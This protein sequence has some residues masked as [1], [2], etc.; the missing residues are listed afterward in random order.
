MHLV[1]LANTAAVASNCR[2]SGN[3]QRFVQFFSLQPCTELRG[4]LSLAAMNNSKLNVSRPRGKQIAH[5]SLYTEMGKPICLLPEVG[6][7]LPKFFTGSCGSS[8][9]IFGAN[10]LHISARPCPICAF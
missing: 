7:N 5:I 2:E 4:E 6:L 1:G 10:I 3:P 9:I 8:S